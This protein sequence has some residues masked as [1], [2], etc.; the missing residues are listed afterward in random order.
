MFVAL[1]LTT[2]STL[3]TETDGTVGEMTYE[4]S[5]SETATGYIL[6][7]PVTV[8]YS[9]GNISVRC[10]ET[11]KLS[12]R[13]P[14]VVYGTS[15]SPMQSFGDSLRLAVGGDSKSGWVKTTMSSRPSGVSTYE[16]ALTVNIPLGVT[17]L[18]VTQSGSGWTQITGCSGKLTV[19][20]GTGGAYADGEYTSVTMS[21]GGGDVKL[22][23]QNNVVLTGTST[24]SA[25]GGT[26]RVV[27]ANAQG[28]KLSA[29]ANEV[30]V[31]Q[32]VMGTNSGT[33]V[34][35]DMGLAGPSITITAKDRA[36][37]TSQ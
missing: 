31:G 13:L 3:A 34:Q 1:L 2:T 23:Q 22:V 25:P 19:S 14:F 21:A 15:E 30:S 24:I 9:G 20:A 27:L 16:A 5:R 4:G 29:K 8:N 10:M 32:T 17:G 28:G 36:E 26:A 12:A 35:G 7:K 18:T 6:G 37:V 33:L 11:E